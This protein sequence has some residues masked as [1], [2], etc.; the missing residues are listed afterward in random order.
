MSY[1]SFFLS[2]VPTSLRRTR[3]A[4]Y[5]QGLGESLD[6]STDGV[7]KTDPGPAGI[8]LTQHIDPQSGALVAGAPDPDFGV[9]ARAKY[10]VKARFPDNPLGATATPDDALD[11]IG[12]DRQ[13]ER[14]T[15]SSSQFGTRLRKAWTTWAFAGTAYGVLQ[16]L[17]FLGYQN[18][19]IYI[20][21]G[22]A[23]TLQSATGDPAAD[24]V[25][26]D[27]HTTPRTMPG[28]W[29]PSPGL[30][31]AVS[32]ARRWWTRYALIFDA[33]L[34]TPA[35]GAPSDWTSAVPAARSDELN[36]IRRIINRW[37]PAYA[38]CDRIVI[39]TSGQVIGWPLSLRIG[40]TGLKFGGNTVVYRS[41]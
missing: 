13:L 20:V 32:P 19:H 35:T 22:A 17:W 11:G 1:S 28:S 18:V 5:L 33:P 16:Q 10:A 40:A 25:R 6:G 39:L 9:T 8:P 38:I 34:P 12:G 24:L 7:I 4:L 21:N 37:Q 27:V 31:S 3:W 2:L 29:W 36:A 14:G 15:S 30:T 26:Y 41:V 23:F